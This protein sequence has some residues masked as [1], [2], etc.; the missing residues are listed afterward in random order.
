MFTDAELLHMGVNLEQNKARVCLR[1][2]VRSNLAYGKFENIIRLIYSSPN[3]V[4][5]CN[6]VVNQLSENVP[7]DVRTF[8]NNFL[9]KEVPKLN[10]CS[11]DNTAFESIIPRNVRTLNELSPYLDNLHSLIQSSISKSDS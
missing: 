2:N 9:L 10:G 4:S 8:I 11:D 7:P 6:D 1:T 5:L 3:S